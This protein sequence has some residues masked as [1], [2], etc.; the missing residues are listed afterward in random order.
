MENAPSTHALKKANGIEVDETV[1]VEGDN[2][3][4]TV[5][6]IVRLHRSNGTATYF[7]LRDYGVSLQC[8][9]EDNVMRVNRR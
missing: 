6:A 2:H 9:H 1:Y 4:Y 5:A 7:L 3:E 8:V